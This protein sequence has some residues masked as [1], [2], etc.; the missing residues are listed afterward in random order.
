M[1]DSSLTRE[2]FLSQLEASWNEFQ[3]WIASLTEE[4]FTVPTDAAGWTVK[5][6]AIHIAA[7]E[8][9][10]L[11]TIEGKSKREA[12][13]ITP[14][15]W[16][17]DD[18]PI[19]AVIQQRYHNMPSNEVKQTLQQNHDLLLKKFDTMTEA[20]FQLPYRHYQPK[21]TQENPIIRWLEWDTIGHY[22][23]HLSWMKVIVG[24]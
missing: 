13:N 23:D 1:S 22:N 5:D 24:Q 10:A 17:Q 14:E 2:Q 7:W 9:A 18:D 15:V 20:D 11:A 12:M 21:S 3:N 4:Q 6:H 19:N 8:K 16:E